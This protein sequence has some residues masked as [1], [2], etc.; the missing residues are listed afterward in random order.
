MLLVW[1]F[2]FSCTGCRFTLGAIH[3]PT[4]G[5]WFVGALFAEQV[6]CAAQPALPTMATLAMAARAAAKLTRPLR[7]PGRAQLVPPRLQPAGA[8]PAARRLEPE[9]GP[10]P[11]P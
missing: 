8:V 7:D 1:L 3:A 9:P 10:E 2:L 4:V 6:R 5:A 11:E